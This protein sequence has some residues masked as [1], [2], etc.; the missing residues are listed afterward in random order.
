MAISFRFPTDR[1][2]Q[3]I[4]KQF[5][6]GSSLLIS[7]VLEQGAVEL[8]AY[9]PFGIWYSLH[10]VSQ[11][12]W[13]FFLIHY[14]WNMRLKF[15]AFFSLLMVLCWV[16]SRGSLSPAWVSTC[17]CQPLWTPSTSMWGRDTFSPSRWKLNYAVWFGFELLRISYSFYFESAKPFW[18]VS[19]K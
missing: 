12:Y 10:N 9:L 1:N 8:L 18:A 14:H 6:W 19:D 17:S 4:D 11:L 7:P 15:T 13:T 5:L 3:T 2:C 16:F